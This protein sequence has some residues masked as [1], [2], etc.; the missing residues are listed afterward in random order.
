MV[1]TIYPYL[2][3]D[4]RAKEAIEFYESV[5]GANVTG[6]M[7]FGDGPSNPEFPIPEEAKNRIMNAHLKIG[8]SEMMLSDTFPGQ[9]IMIGN[10]VTVAVIIESADETK[11]IFEKLA[12]GGEIGMP[13][14]KTFWSPAYGAVIDKF[15]V[16]WQVS[17]ASEQ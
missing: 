9:P 12:I 8:A 5:L 16:S 17:A 4:G 7:T 10:H 3:F 15:G 14:Q 2:V 11:E 1:S 13:L 6:V